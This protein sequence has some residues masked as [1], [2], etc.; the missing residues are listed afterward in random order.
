MMRNIDECFVLAAALNSVIQDFLTPMAAH[1]NNG[2]CGT[3][4]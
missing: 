4:Y 1:V 3:G 2:N